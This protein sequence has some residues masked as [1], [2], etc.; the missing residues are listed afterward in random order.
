MP[1]LII[2]EFKSEQLNFGFEILTLKKKLTVETRKLGI[3]F[4]KTFDRLGG[5]Q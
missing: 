3:H 1:Y 2:T 5:N 4:S